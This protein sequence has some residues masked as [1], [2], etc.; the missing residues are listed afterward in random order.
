MCNKENLSRLKLEWA[1]WGLRDL[2]DKD[3]LGE[4]APPI[5]L[6]HLVPIGY[7]SISFPNWL[8]NIPH[9]LPNLVSV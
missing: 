3:V 9:Y 8:T 5:G 6:K 2:E 4:L 7:D 1:I